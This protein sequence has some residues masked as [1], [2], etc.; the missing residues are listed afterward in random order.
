MP[1]CM[2]PPCSPLCCM[3]SMSCGA[4]AGFSCPTAVTIASRLISKKLVAHIG[5]TPH[6][7]LV[8]NGMPSSYLHPGSSR[9][10]LETGL[11]KKAC[12]MKLS[13]SSGPLQFTEK[14][15]NGFWNRWEW[16]QSGGDSDSYEVG[17]LGL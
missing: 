17:G 6:A 4:S 2:N 15:R 12:T 8:R 11:P 16:F 3:C 7:R 10:D 14:R 9:C 13:H 5:V 1:P